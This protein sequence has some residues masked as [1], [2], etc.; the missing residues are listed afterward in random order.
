PHPTKLCNTMRSCPARLNTQ[1][2]VPSSVLVLGVLG[3]SSPSS[4]LTPRHSAASPRS[5]RHPALGTRPPRPPRPRPPP[6][7]RH[8][9][10]PP[11]AK[12]RGGA[13]GQGRLASPS[14]RRGG[15]RGERFPEGESP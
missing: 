7:A 8:D 4:V 15:G 11:A 5:P 3:G 13:G 1:P 9:A 12:A 2:L 10:R 14:P 6:A